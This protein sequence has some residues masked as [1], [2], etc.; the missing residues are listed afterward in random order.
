MQKLFWVANSLEVFEYILGGYIFL[1]LG[2]ENLEILNFKEII[3]LLLFNLQHVLEALR[4]F[5]NSIKFFK[6]LNLVDFN[7]T[8]KFKI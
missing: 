4:K 1:I 5:P 2:K 7:Q 8:S 3:F 6:F